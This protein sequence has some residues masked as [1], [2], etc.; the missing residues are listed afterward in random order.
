MSYI[1]ETT[2][3]MYWYLIKKDAGTSKSHPL[4]KNIKFKNIVWAMRT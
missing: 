4:K 1:S 2:V 3:Y